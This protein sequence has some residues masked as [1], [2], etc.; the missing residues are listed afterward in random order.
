MSAVTCYRVA[1]HDDPDVHMLVCLGCALGVDDTMSVAVEMLNGPRALPPI[2]ECCLRVIK[3]GEI[4][5]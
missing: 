2:C 3:P 4:P 5:A 1:R